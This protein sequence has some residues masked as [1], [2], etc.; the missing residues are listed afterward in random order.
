MSHV[1]RARLFWLGAALFV[2]S[3]VAV[4]LSG[5]S[6]DLSALGASWQ[7]LDPALLQTRLLESLVHLHS[8][9]PVFNAFLGIVLKAAGGASNLIFELLFL[10]L[11]AALYF[12]TFALMRCLSVSPRTAFAVSTLFALSPSVL[13]YELWLFYTLPLALLVALLAL[14]FARSIERRSWA[15]IGSFFVVLA[16]LCGLHGIFHLIYFAGCIAALLLACRGARLKVLVAAAVPFAL[17]VGIYAKNAVL[18]GQFTTST[19]L[20]MN[21]ALRRVETV[22]L[23]QRKQLVAEGQLSEVALI[24]PFDPLAHYP[25]RYAQ[26]PARFA[27]IPALASAVKSTG[28]PNLNHIGYIA[29]A[30]SYQADTKQVLRRYP[31]VLVQSLLRGWYEYF[32]SSSNYWFLERNLHDS[33]LL[34]GANRL[35][36][37]LFYG[38]LIGNTPGL[39]LIVF[40]PALVFFALRV[41]RKPGASTSFELGSEQRWLLA[42]AA[43]TIA[44]VAVVANTL[45]TLENM[46]IRFMTDPLLA[47]ILAF[48]I[49]HWLRPR[50]SESTLFRPRG[51]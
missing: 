4:R 32:K 11:G 48:W 6:F 46:R 9:P 5:A 16:L 25:A 50:L 47:A 34:R 21:V 36:D 18:F 29:I 33:W 28:E 49:E 1:R 20:G 41:A 10:G 31:K 37:F 22:P 51:R 23:D 42:F 19:W 14:S 7:H 27:G 39:L 30:K 44:F 15:A 45:N 13:L 17:V 26:V 35:F 2:A 43:A 8:Q 40:I 24:T 3:R 12:V 38:V